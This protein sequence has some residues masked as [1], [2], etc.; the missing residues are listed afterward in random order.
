MLVETH[1][2]SMSEQYVYLETRLAKW[3]AD[4]PQND[5]ITVMGIKI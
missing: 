1:T 4:V 2:L 3:M 5:D